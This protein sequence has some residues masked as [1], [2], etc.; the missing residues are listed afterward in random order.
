[1]HER[2]LL[3]ENAGAL[4]TS[5]DG[6]T[7]TL[8]TFGALSQKVKSGTKAKDVFTGQPVPSSGDTL[9]LDAYRVYQ[10]SE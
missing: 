7:K 10:W 6:K 5:A 9:R 3:P 4:W 1:M 2:T 8:W